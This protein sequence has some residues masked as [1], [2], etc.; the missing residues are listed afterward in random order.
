M[1]RIAVMIARCDELVALRR[2]G[3][4]APRGDPLADIAF[5]ASVGRP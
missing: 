3:T 2:S 5:S 4:I 1:S